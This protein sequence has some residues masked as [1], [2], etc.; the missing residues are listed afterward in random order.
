MISLTLPLLHTLQP[1]SLKFRWVSHHF[2]PIHYTLTILC[3]FEGYIIQKVP[4]GKWLGINVIL[5]GIITAS[6]G[7]VKNYH[8]LLVCRILLGTSEA[9]IQP[10]L[11]IITGESQ[12]IIMSISRN[13]L[14]LYYRN[15]VYEG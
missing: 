12:I 3:A 5:W 13:P 7:A 6:T 15:V 2:H 10:C 14:N 4:P 9:A 11:M 8:H 1:L